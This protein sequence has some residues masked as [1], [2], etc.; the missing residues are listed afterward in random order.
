[1]K[2]RWFLYTAL[3]AALAASPSTAWAAQ[4]GTASRSAYQLARSTSST[5]RTR[6]RTVA[7]SLNVMGSSPWKATP[8]SVETPWMMPSATPAAA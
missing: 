6:F 4:E 1:M 2:K 8:S 7:A 3:A 5:A